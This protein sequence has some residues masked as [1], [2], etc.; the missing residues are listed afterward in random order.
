MRKFFE[1]AEKE[2]I[3]R[4]TI[5]GMIER[6]LEEKKATHKIA[7]WIKIRQIITIIIGLLLIFLQVLIYFKIDKLIEA[8]IVS[9]FHVNETLPK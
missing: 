9:F 1:E 4:E 8:L 3:S 5:I 2:G 6:D 7:K